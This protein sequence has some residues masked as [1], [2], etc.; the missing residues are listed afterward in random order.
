MCSS[1]RGAKRLSSLSL[2]LLLGA[3]V[4]ADGRQGGL[5]GDAA[6]LGGVVRDLGWDGDRD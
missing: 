1:R 2:V 6:E 3:S 5:H 4:G